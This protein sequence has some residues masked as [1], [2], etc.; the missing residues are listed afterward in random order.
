ME[1]APPAVLQQEMAPPPEAV[2]PVPPT[3]EQ[4][5]AMQPG[6]EEQIPSPD[7]SGEHGRRSF[8]QVAR[9]LGYRATAKLYA[10][11]SRF[12]T[13]EAEGE[14]EDIKRAAFIG[15]AVLGSYVAFKYGV[16]GHHSVGSL[17]KDVFDTFAHN[18]SDID[19]VNKHSK[20]MNEITGALGNFIS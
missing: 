15:T 16:S 11:S 18:S 20:S 8:M 19:N 3:P 13:A 7:Q 9:D 10:E 6:P 17:G 2:G 5:P 4:P 12:A 14:G 1:T